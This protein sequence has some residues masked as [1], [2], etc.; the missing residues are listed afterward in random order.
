M[1]E[2]LNKDKSISKN[3]KGNFTLTAFNLM[4]IAILCQELSDYSGEL[5]A[6][7]ELKDLGGITKNKTFKSEAGE[8]EAFKQLLSHFTI[9]NITLLD[10]IQMREEKLIK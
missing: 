8:L 2:D 7:S 4:R 5:K 6:W 10:Y 9:R 3:E 1:K